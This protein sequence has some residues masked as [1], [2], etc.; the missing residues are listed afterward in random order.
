MS[1]VSPPNQDVRLIENT[2]SQTMLRFVKRC[3]TH[4]HTSGTKVFS[5]DDVH[6]FRIDFRNFFIALLVTKFIPNSDPNCLAHLG[7]S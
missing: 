5:D 4:G 1:H 6:S 2:L 3:G 7:Y